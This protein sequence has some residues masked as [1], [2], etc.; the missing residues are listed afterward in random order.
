M[1]EGGLASVA[2]E[3]RLACLDRLGSLAT[4]FSE[5]RLECCKSVSRYVLQIHNSKTY[6][7][8][9]RSL[10]I[11]EGRFVDPLNSLASLARAL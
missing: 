1:S 8:E 11:N 3:S 4:G 10:F 9:E 5:V 2:A 6:L 7:T